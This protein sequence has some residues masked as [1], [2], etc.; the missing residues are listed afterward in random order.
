[1]PAEAAG[2]QSCSQNDQELKQLAGEIFASHP[3]GK[4][5]GV[6]L[7][8]YKLNEKPFN[9]GRQPYTPTPPLNGAQQQLLHILEGVMSPDFSLADRAQSDGLTFIHK[10]L[11]DVDIYFVCNLQPARIVTDVGFRVT[12]KVPQR[13]DAITG[14]VAPV[15][16]F[17]ADNNVTKLPLEF[18]PWESA[19]FVFAPGMPPLDNVRPAVALP[20]PMTIAGLWQMKLEGHGFDTFITNITTL[21]SWTA[22]SR[23]RHFSG[24]GRYEAEFMMPAEQMIPGANLVLALG[25]VGNIAEVELNGQNVGVAWIAPHRLDITRAVRAGKNRLVIYVTNTLINYVTG[26]K[27]PPDVPLDLQ[28][29]LG[30]ANPGVYEY[31]N[32]A[33]RE[34]S[35]TD[36]PPS[37][38]IGPVTIHWECP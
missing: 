37:G 33:S 34:M 4:G 7:P 21:V 2:L 18:E 14:K 25:Q 19:F 5:G 12:G 36:L 3:V 17:H 27:V 16:H 32:L 1:V 28:P 29:R 23:T 9:P 11:D 30:K 6:I 31:S 13:W 35:E 20:E 10:R 26:L 8:Q 24:T 15:A 22:A 38:L